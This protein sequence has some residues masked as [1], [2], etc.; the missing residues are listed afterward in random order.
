LLSEFSYLISSFIPLLYSGFAFFPAF[1]GQYG[2]HSFA[3]PS[4]W[5]YWDPGMNRSLSIV[6]D[7]LQ[8]VS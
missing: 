6:A 3:Y 2:T 4:N 7:K 1:W 5:S 8:I